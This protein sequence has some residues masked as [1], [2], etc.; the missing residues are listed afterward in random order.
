MW[1]GPGADVARSRCRCGM[2]SGAD[3]AWSPGQMW[4]GPGADVARSRCRCG[5]VPVQ[6]WRGPGA[7]V[8]GAVLGDEFRPS[9]ADRAEKLRH[10]CTSHGGDADGLERRVELV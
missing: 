9:L 6:M 5:E 7:D 3:V 1:R 8:A 2:E 10:A 4:R